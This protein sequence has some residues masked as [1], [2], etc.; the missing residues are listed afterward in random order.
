MNKKIFPTIFRYL[1]FKFQMSTQSTLLLLNSNHYETLKKVDK[2]LLYMNVLPKAYVI[3]KKIE[4]EKELASL[5][6]K[7]N[8]DEDT[9]KNIEKDI[10]NGKLLLSDTQV[11]IQTKEKY[12]QTLNYELEVVL[13][14]IAASTQREEE[15]ESKIQVFENML[16]Y[17]EEYDKIRK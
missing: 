12:L 13:Q 6:H 9:F 11:T 17:S 8:I 16:L 15:L 14:K 3:S 7:R 1:I 10:N 5:E 4:S 2:N